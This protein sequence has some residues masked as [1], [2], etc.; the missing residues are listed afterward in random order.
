MKAVHEFF[1][2]AGD[3]TALIIELIALAIAIFTILHALYE[4]LVVFKMDFTRF[5]ESE[6]L[7]AGMITTLET[8]MVAEILKTVLVTRDAQIYDLIT[9]VILV[10]V[11][12]F[13]THHLEKSVDKRRE[14]KGKKPGESQESSE[15]SVN[16]TVK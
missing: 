1:Y 9:L 15:E 3:W 4:L 6:T 5:N 11:R 13:L 14:K 16:I 2:L 12:T 7:P 10:L 8:L